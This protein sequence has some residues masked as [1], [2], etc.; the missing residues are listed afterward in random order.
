M[1][2]SNIFLRSVLDEIPRLLGQLNRNP[3]SR[4]YGSFDRAFW[5]YRTN[6]ISS[7]RY[8]EAILTLTL[9]YRTPFDGND[10]FGDKKILEWIRAAFDFSVSIQN[11]DGSFNES[12]VHE[13][14]FVATAFIVA[15]LSRALL[16][17]DIKEIPAREVIIKSLQ[18]AADWIQ[19]R[20]EHLVFNQEAGSVAALW[21]VFHLTGD[22]RYRNAAEKK[23]DSILRHQKSAGWWD[24]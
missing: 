20:G 14:S 8:Q 16:M 12:Y 1:K 21:G 17:L 6:D 24:E 7:A 3:A 4:T 5:H 15:A 9:L 18:S 10:Y 13:G 19:C 23:I 22:G 11:R 2:N